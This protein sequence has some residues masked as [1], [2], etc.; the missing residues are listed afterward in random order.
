MSVIGAKQG[1][2]EN[3]SE[4]RMINYN[5]ADFFLKNLIRASVYF[6]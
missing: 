2:D 3:G 4:I 6:L 1:H 5:K